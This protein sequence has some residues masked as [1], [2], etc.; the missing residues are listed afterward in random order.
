MK[1]TL[2]ILLAAVLMLSML[3][4]ASLAASQYA[5]VVGGWLRLR[6]GA[7]FDADTIT[8]YYTGSQVKILGSHGVWYRVQTS[9]GRIGYMHSDYLKLKGS[10]SSSSSGS[11]N[12]YVTSHNGYGVRLRTGPGTGYRIIKTYDV[13]TPVTVL[14][15]GKYWSK[16]SIYGTTGYM[17][18]QFI[19]THAGSSSS[20]KVIGYATI[21]SRNGYGVRLRTG[22][23]TEYGKIGTYAVGTTVAVLEKGAVWDRIRVGSRVGWMM[24]EFLQYHGMN[25]VTSVILNTVSPVVGDVLKVKAI[26]PSGATVRYEWKVGNDVYTGATYT[27]SNADVNKTIQ[28]K[29]T[30]TG[31]YYGTAKSAVTNPVIAN[32]VVYDVKL[33]TTAP[34]V[35]TTLKMDSIKPSGAKVNYQWSTGSTVLGTGETYTVQTADVGKVIR[36]T[37]T[38]KDGY[39]GSDYAETAAVAERTTLTGV[40]LSHSEPSVGTTLGFTTSPSGATVTAQWIRGSVDIPGATANTYT[41][42]QDDFDQIIS[43]RVTGTDAYDGTVTSAGTAKVKAAQTTPVVG[44]VTTTGL[45]VN[46]TATPIQLTATGGGDMEWKLVSG[47]LPDGMGLS[48][49]GKITGTPT[50]ADTFTFVVS[51]TNDAGTGTKEI[52]LTVAAQPK[53]D[54]VV[55]NVEFTAQAGYAD[56]IKVIS[57]TNSGNADAKDIAVA[58]EGENFTVISGNT[59]I[60]VNATDETWGVK[61]KDGL[62]VGTYTGKVKVTCGDATKEAA[63]TFTVKET[64]KAPAFTKGSLADAKVGKDYSETVSAEGTGTLK[65][66]ITG[67][68]LPGGLNLNA[69]TGLISG[70]PALAGDYSVTITVTDVDQTADNIATQTFSLKVNPAD[71]SYT[72]EENIAPQITTDGFVSGTQGT[73]YTA[74]TLSALHTGT[75]E[76]S[77]TGG[78]LPAGMK[79][80]NGVISGTPTES[81]TFQFTVT[82]KVTGQETNNTASRTFTLEIAAGTPPSGGGEGGGAVVQ[83]APELN[84]SSLENAT[85]GASYST[86]ITVKADSPFTW[87][88]TGGKL[89]AGLSFNEGN[90][91]GTPEAGT[92]GSYSFTITV[93]DTDDTTLT[94]VKTFN[95]TVVN[96][97]YTVK[98]NDGEGSGSY[99]AGVTVSVKADSK[100]GYNFTGWDASG[101]SVSNDASTSF[102]MPAGNVTLTAK[103]E[104]IAVKLDAPTVSW[105]DSKNVTWNSVPNAT[106][107]EVQIIRKDGSVGSVKTVE[108]GTS[109]QSARIAVDGDIAYV[110]AIGDGVA[111]LKSNEGTAEYTNE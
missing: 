73:E 102:D 64:P 82:V 84:V 70:K 43:V 80:E 18:S 86:T 110:W 25:E 26:S 83:V 48:K 66:S 93:A 103:Y 14:Q 52:T 46:V 21:W 98:V 105:A 77:L 29:V 101:V 37:V 95:L 63:I 36:L 59:S 91:S 96:P 2:A 90:I 10:S 94:D 75:L 56:V 61:A 85:V 41:L 1:R 58:V 6:A 3:P 24:N 100:A 44:D 88:V 27:V 40:S 8:S 7:S 4:A 108:G 99:E 97:K 22:P 39:T 9:D 69:D 5:E 109:F 68:S 33:N 50:V 57:I 19:S 20:D 55:G 17:M 89:P 47:K 34:V 106:K 67:G 15:S 16:I 71:T 111:Y 62:T 60:G 87:A 13:G 72:P 28:L 12:A 81:G 54:L 65:W 53:P 23:G 32:T 92:A 79:L 78:K 51:A 38:G 42:T 45:T 31:S 35:G 30:G 11:Y 76:W 49:E 107:Y 104:K 74:V